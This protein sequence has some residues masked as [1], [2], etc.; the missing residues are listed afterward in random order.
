[1]SSEAMQL[2]KNE[3]QLVE[4]NALERDSGAADLGE[5]M[6]ERSIWGTSCG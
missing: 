4:E 2:S 3:I 1:M 6:L 5:P